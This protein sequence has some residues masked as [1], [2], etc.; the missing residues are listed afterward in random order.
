MQEADTMPLDLT[1]DWHVT[2][3]VDASIRPDFLGL[4]I[5]FRMAINQDGPQ[6]AGY[7]EK[8][9]VD[10]QRAGADEASRLE[11]T[12]WVSEAGVQISLIEVGPARTII[13]DITWRALGSD[14]MAGSFRVDLAQTSGRSEAVRRTM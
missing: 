9:L 3:H 13:G 1:G 14:H 5:E 12:G 6:L 4:A 2:H 8:F 7:G 10:Q 11:V